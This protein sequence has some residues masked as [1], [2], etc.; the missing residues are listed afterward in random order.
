MYRI[1]AICKNLS[2]GLLI[3]LMSSCT[4]LAKS[5]A[6]A[7]SSSCVPPSSGQ[8]GNGV[9]WP[10]GADAGTFTYQCTGAYAGKWTNAYY[11]YDPVT[12]ARSALY[13]P[14]YN[15]DCS[16]RTWTEAA[17]EYSPGAGAYQE[18][19]ISASDPGLPTNWPT[20]PLSNEVGQTNGQSSSPTSGTDIN[21]KS[22]SISS[23]D[24]KNT[25]YSN[26]GNT[27]FSDAATGDATVQSNATGGSA[28][29]GDATGIANVANLLQSTGNVFGPNTVMFTAA[30]NGDVNGNILLNPSTILG[31]GSGSSNTATNS[32]R[33][34]A[35]NTNSTDASLSNNVNVSAQ[36]GNAT[37]ANNTTGGN[38]TSGNADA[39]ANLMNLI[40]STVDAGKSFIG[41]IDINGDL[42]GNILLPQGVIDQLLASNS[43]AG[44]NIGAASS[45][46]D[47][48]TDA[49]STTETINNT[50]G[51]SAKSGNAAV[52]NNSSGGNAMTGSANTNVT[53]LNLTGSD[54]VGTNDL[55]VFVNVLGKWYGM[56]MNAPA[57]TTAAELGGSIS[58]SGPVSDS[59]LLNEKTANTAHFAISNNVNVS[60]QSGNATVAN[61]TTGGNAT[62]GNA[63]AAINLLNLEGSNLSLSNWFGILFI[64]VFGIW[65][66]SFGI[67]NPEIATAGPTANTTE[68]VV[69]ANAQETLRANFQR[70][71]T[72]LATTVPGTSNT[73]GGSP[74][75][76]L[77]D[78]AAAP[79]AERVQGTAAPVA[80]NGSRASYTLPAL[81]IFAAAL[82]LAASERDRLFRRNK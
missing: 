66:G 33:V 15:Y 35:N 16:T 60:A 4:L 72:F 6:F 80:G 25:T 45:L 81:C 24:A 20:S 31:T 70:F 73:N 57:G 37:V 11:V 52:T 12:G 51:S 74:N 21:G 58:S 54:V 65:N 56:I 53:V 38:A 75:A 17:W 55:L 29:T 39:A 63:D 49:N 68:N 3:L 13:N 78:Y 1:I 34:N 7:D 26:A 41:T 36:S 64:N 5:T 40:S 10:V 32:L 9:R 23:N 43:G 18:S 22:S 69:Q 71:S 27:I 62:S 19:R 46:T 28:T 59:A 76:V 61:N 48:S 82:L 14:D 77:G 79:T 47:T 50:L 67:T 8:N 42:N 2:L 30:I 44:A